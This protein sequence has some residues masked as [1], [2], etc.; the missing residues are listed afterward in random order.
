MPLV[1]V[2]AAGH[3]RP[4]LRR[5]LELYRATIIRYAARG[6]CS[7]RPDAWTQRS[8]HTGLIDHLDQAHVGRVVQ[9][10]RA[11][12]PRRGSGVLFLSSSLRLIP[13]AALEGVGHWTLKRSF[14][15]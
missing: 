15:P 4:V 2:D 11:A 12:T 1:V 5:L 7:V 14:N 10:S 6:S 13:E 9:L 8:S 3:E